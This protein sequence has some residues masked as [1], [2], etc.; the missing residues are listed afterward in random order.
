MKQVDIITYYFKNDGD[1]PNNILPVVIYKNALQHVANKDFEHLF[2]QNGWANNWHD[3]ILTEDHFHSN[4]HEV[5]GLQSGQVSLMLGG[6]NGEIVNVET[7]D[8]IILPAGI[9]HY[10]VDNSVEYQFVGGYPNGAEWN[11]KFSLQKE[12]SP[13]ILTEIANIP[14]PQKDPL[15]GIDGPLSTYWK[16]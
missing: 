16:Y 7:G 14:I 10:S 4:T 12:D 8:V 1:I 13:S 15:F 11:L 3:I 5:L 2:C 6:K 9:G